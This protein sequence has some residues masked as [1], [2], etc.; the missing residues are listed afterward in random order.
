MKNTN[1][2]SAPMVVAKGELVT[3][4]YGHGDSSVELNQQAGTG[5]ASVS[6]NDTTGS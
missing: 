4:T 5:E 1:S 2:Y 3:R 6:A